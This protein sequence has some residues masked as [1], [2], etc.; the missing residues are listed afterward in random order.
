MA[1]LNV[2][3]ASSGSSATL[4]SITLNPSSIAGGTTSQG[5]V[6][7]STAAP[8]SGA[9]V[10]LTSS[11]T[12]AAS[13]PAS[14]SVASGANSATFTAT[15]GSVTASASVVI[16]ASYGGATQTATLVVSAPAVS[17]LTV[18]P[19]AVLGGN[20]SQGTV[21]LSA[22]APSS[23]AVVSLS[24]ANPS[25][26]TVPASVSVPA[27]AMNASFVL[28]TNSVKAT[29]SVVST[30][31]YG[32]GT[33]SAVLNVQ[34]PSAG[35]AIPQSGWKLLSVD[36]QETTC[37]NYAA[38]NSF[39]GN[40]ATFWHT[41]ICP[42]TPGVPHNIQINLG[43]TYSIGGFTYL[44]RQDG[45]SHGWISQ[46]QFYVSLDGV[47]WGSPVSSGTLNYGTAKTG[48]PGASVPPAI[49]VLFPATSARYVQLR[50][51]SEITGG[52]YISMAELNVLAAS[53][54]SG[55]T[56]PPTVSITSPGSGATVA[57]TI[58]VNATAS[59]NVAVANV[60]LEVDGSAVGSADT[61]SPY[62]FSL[63]TT[64]LSNGTHSLTAVATDSSGNQ[65]TS[66]AVSVTVA[67]QAAVQPAYANNGAGCPINT[68]TGGPTDAVS[69]Y[70]CPLPNPTGAGNTLV[71][72]LR[73]RN[74]NSPT[75]SF[76][77][78]IGG[79]TYTQAAS[80][81]DTA[82]GNTVSRLYYASNIKPGVNVVTVNFSASTTFVEM[83][84]FEFYNVGGL[85]E[86]VCSVGNGTA[87]SS[88]ALSSLTNSGDLVVH[89]GMADNGG[90]AIPYISSCS[91]GSQPNVAWTMRASL[92]AGPEPMCFQYGVYTS[93]SSFAP[94]M[95]FGSSV[96]YISLA[97]AFKAAATGTAPPSGIRVAYVQHDNG[98]SLTAGSIGLELP[99]SGNLA[100]EVA[101][102]S[103]ASNTLNS[104]NYATSV[105]DGTNSWSQIGS[106]YLSNTGSSQEEPGQIWYARNA[107]PG[108]YVLLNTENPSSSGAQAPFPLTWMLYD[109]VGASSNPLDL[110]FGGNGNGLATFSNTN[111][112]GP[113]TTF[114]VAPSAPNELII[115]AVGYEWNT[116]TGVTTP[117]G[118]QFIS[119]DYSGET[120][121]SWVDSNG[122]YA[123]F[124]NGNSTAAETW[125]W[126]HDTSQQAGSG[127]GLA[128]GA[129]FQPA[130][131]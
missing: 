21:T 62:S 29:T 107:T 18:S 116:F 97:A 79:N 74:A 24:S 73:Y 85:D 12:A 63:D 93:T 121:Y 94:L 122:G 3:A 115:T 86:A 124:Y 82:N 30:A 99:L 90:S 71:I 77:D 17:S 98:G 118:A 54:G 33:A 131:P 16:S 89:F 20:T 119:C 111:S 50:A 110:G 95:H 53:S 5:T 91:V 114:T 108:L 36:S 80:C 69:S 67:N 15:G 65:A 58:A 102:T 100:V 10:A 46:Y 31:S 123:I 117:S 49:Q 105:S 127:R 27:G 76:A 130:N 60:Q 78:N 26:V 47:N 23:G 56:T 45:C 61:S 4:S 28:S 7:L 109:I 11:N 96:E 52:P 43:T 51:L 19:G 66:V 70:N 35:T 42:S 1:E 92:V 72:W 129:A 83:E 22:A 32:G 125:T 75:V 59:D 37:G 126:T 55:D 88:G 101:I 81:T 25:A 128:I 14:V 8:A 57:G 6:T 13:V 9:V 64:S 38:V 48:C 40:P 34:S 120:N 106:S 103:C 84:P 113:V 87:I 2:L 41:Q 44:P 104:C 68:V 112:S 39:D